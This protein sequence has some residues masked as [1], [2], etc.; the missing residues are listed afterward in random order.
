MTENEELIRRVALG[1]RSAESLLVEKN[2]GLIRAAARRF[3]GRCAGRG[4]EAP[5]L[6]PLASKC[7]I[8]PHIVSLLLPFF[9]YIIP[10]FHI[11]ESFL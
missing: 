7:S 9:S 3:L 5:V 1:D 11:D 2:G 10:A 8:V 6:F 4:L